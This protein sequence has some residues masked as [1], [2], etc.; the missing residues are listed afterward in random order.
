MGGRLLSG[1]PAS[2]YLG[3]AFN[4]LGAPHAE[5]SGFGPTES[6]FP[7]LGPSSG[8]SGYFSRKYV[9][10]S[11]TFWGTRS[12]PSLSSSR[13]RWS[14]SACRCT[15]G[16]AAR[17]ES[18]PM[19]I[20]GGAEMRIV[21]GRPQR[22][23]V[24]VGLADHHRARGAQPRHHVRVVRGRLAAPGEADPGRPAGHIEIVLERQ[25]NAVQ[26]S[27]H[28][29]TPTPVGHVRLF[30]HQA[31]ALVDIAMQLGVEPFDRLLVR[32]G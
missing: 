10:R 23:L 32:V 17:A 21:G 13:T 14:A 9:A 31:R 28:A 20:V 18:V 7:G 5:P 25:R 15:T 4:V 27:D 8:F 6:G 3:G 1:S 30:L 24:H 2:A 19:R 29:L 22:A 12:S 16:G 11:V 26:P